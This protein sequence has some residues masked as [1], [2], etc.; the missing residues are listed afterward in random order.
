MKLYLP[1]PALSTIFQKLLSSQRSGTILGRLLLRVLSV[2][3][4]REMLPHVHDPRGAV[5]RPHP[6]GT[7]PHRGRPGVPRATAGGSLA[8]GR[9]RLEARI[10]SFGVDKASSVRDPKC[11]TPV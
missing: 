5:G 9:P 7:C 1:S 8:R 6:G 2:L 10:L 4:V 11:I 3:G